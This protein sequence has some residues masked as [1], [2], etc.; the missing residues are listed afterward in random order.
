M[1]AAW[2]VAIVGLVLSF[3]A[4]WLIQHQLG[5]HQQLEFKWVA[6]N[7]HR[8]LN[9]E[10]EN[11]LEAVESVRDLFLVSE[12]VS[13]ED[14]RTLVRSLLDRH[15][16]IHALAWLP[17]VRRADRPGIQEAAGEAHPGSQTAGAQSQA[18][19]A[20]PAGQDSDF[21]VLYVEPYA[22]N[23]H[24][25]GVEYAAHP[26]FRELLARARDDRS[27]VV[28]ERI[29][30]GEAEAGQFG[31]A[32]FLPVYRTRR[33]ATL[34]ERRQHLA[35]Y[36]VGIFR[37]DELARIATAVLEPRGVEFLIRD[38]AAPEDRQFLGFYS[39][40]LSPRNWSSLDD[41]SMWSRKRQPQITQL[42]PVAD[43]TWSIVYAPTAQFRSAEGFQQGPW[44][45]LASGL[46]LTVLLTSYLLRVKQDALVRAKMENALREREERFRQM[47]D[48]IQEVFW[49]QT[50][51]LSQVLYVSPAYEKIWGRSRESLYR[52][53]FSFLE[54][55][56]PKDRPAVEAAL[57]KEPEEGAEQVFR[58]VRPDGSIRWVRS[59]EFAVHN[60]R[61][62]IYRIAGIR[63]DITEIKRAEQALRKSEKD[64]RS[65]F[66]QSPDIIK[67]VDETGRIR[68][69]NRSLPELST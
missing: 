54:G 66:S 19:A 68:S 20:N 52:N 2:S 23:Q 1:I 42:L 56:H 40:R 33:P 26:R 39:S 48:A 8:A 37:I 24:L 13:R 21:P 3:G 11:E 5:A 67:T 50:P 25:L 9:K 31:F 29:R 27:M 58:V 64:L 6:E 46:L 14:F 34:S 55:V 18:A 57:G 28:S 30:L 10:I 61:G 69:M 63:E 49:I 12:E 7:R 41:W 4:F 65:L 15:P 44:V 53:P 38:D 22:T 59:R 17:R 36:A 45:V 43:R 47:T 51:E 32:A 16:G 60:A 62:Q 35:G